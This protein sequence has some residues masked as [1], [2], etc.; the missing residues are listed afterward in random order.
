MHPSKE[1]IATE[2]KKILVE[3]LF[4]EV[5]TDKIKDTDS[6]STDIGL[7]SVGQIELVSIIEERYRLKLDVKEAAAD[8]KTIGSTAD[9]IW[10]NVHAA[11][12]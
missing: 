8:M 12:D 6:L 2:L 5:P 9:Y 11:H 1:E 4:V 7:D 10:R 3:D